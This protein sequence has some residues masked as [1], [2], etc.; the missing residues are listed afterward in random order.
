MFLIYLT[1]CETVS[2]NY[3]IY[4]CKFEAL[5][6]FRPLYLQLRALVL[7]GKSNVQTIVYVCHD[8]I[9]VMV[10]MTVVIT[11]MKIHCFVKLPHVLQVSVN[12]HRK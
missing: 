6:S 7:L 2:Y 11:V 8:D 9:F 4:F 3:V 12:T 10:I 1:F 5:S